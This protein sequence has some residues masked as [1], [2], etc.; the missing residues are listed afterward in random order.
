[1]AKHI[2]S[3]TGAPA[4]TPQ[5]I[6]HHYIDTTNKVAYISVG[7]SSSADWETSDAADVA[8]DLATHVADTANPHAVTKTQ[9]GLGNADNTSDVNKPVST[10]TQTALDDKLDDSMATNKL[11]GRGT[12]GTGVVEQITLGTN[13]SLTGTTLNA[14][15][16]GSWGTISGTLTDQVDLANELT[17]L[18]DGDGSYYFTSTASDLGGGRLEMTKAIP[19]GGGASESFTG[20]TDGQYLSSFCT[21]SGYPNAD[22]LP[23]GP[24]SFNCYAV[25]T[26]G[27]QTCKLYA[28]FYIREV[29][30]TQYLL[31]TTPVTEAITGVS[32]N[33]KAHTTMGPYKTMNLTDRL[34]IRIK[35]EVTG[36]GTAP[37]VQLRFQGTELSRTKFPCEPVAPSVAWGAITGTLTDQTDLDTALDGKQDDITASNNQLIYANGSGV[38][39][40]LPGIFKDTTSGGFDIGLT[41]NPNAGSGNI[42]IHD[43]TINLNPIANTPNETYTLQNNQINVDTDDDGFSIGTAGTSIKMLSHYVSAQN[44]SDMGEVNFIINNFNIGNGT[45]AI[46]VNGWSYSTGFGTVNANVN[47]SGPMQGYGYQPNVNASATIG[48][49]EYTNAFYD[50]SNIGCAAPGHTS[51]NASPIIASINNTTNY[52]GFNTSPS[53]TTFTGNA[54][55]IGL[56]V[57]GNLGTFNDNGYFHGVNVN[58]TITSARYAAGLNITMDGVTPYAGVNASVTIQDLTFEFNAPGS[59]NNVYTMEFT[60]GATAGSEVVTILGNAV[61]IQIENG[62]STATQVKAA[63]DAAPSFVGAITTTITGTAS[64]AQVADGPDSFAGGID[65]GR[66]LAAYLDGDVEIT[67]S[68]SF[69]GALSIGKL[70][71]FASQAMVDGGGTPASV[72]SLISQ[73]T[74]GDNITLTSADT[75]AVNTAALISIGTNSSV[76]TAFIGIA[77]LG[78]PAVLGMQT[79]STVDRVYG[80]LF[81]LSLD[82]ASTGGTADEIGLCRAVAIPN[83]VTT[84]NNLYGYLFD[85]PFGDP[86]TKTFGFY[87]RPGKNNY[88]NGTLLIGGTPVSDDTVTNSSIGLEIKSTTKTFMN[89]RMTTSE[90]NALTAVNGMQVYN[91][92]TDKLQVYAGGSWVDL[93]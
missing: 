43:N 28:E 80:A 35:A 39:E 53:I 83:G 1:M 41:Q 69:A 36:V 92:T 21:V 6:G 11:L 91:S 93:H 78:L 13:L 73:P 57:T 44:K 18:V 59:F 60:T 61:T 77:A 32:T 48:T 86:G 72:H 33:V 64:N 58:P 70:S 38:V 45:D 56:S 68:L 5:G 66:V 31:G 19:A 23:A 26:G 29:G 14:S 54:G 63:C 20:V 89:A 87:D 37:D 67:G 16:G 79:G 47:V 84:V 51:F 49:G 85:L 62:V 50:S 74:V 17:N 42:A 30:G 27:T 52:T 12:A 9:V 10:A 8:A 76:S 71:A 3:G 25:Q 24:L 4:T 2:F 82:A 65:A 34:L 22:H 40:G 90:R 88:F 75:I 7:T 46:D 81:A 15:G 55:C